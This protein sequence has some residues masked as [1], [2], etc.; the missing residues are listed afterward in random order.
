[1]NKLIEIALQLHLIYQINL[2][3]KLLYESYYFLPSLV[4]KGWS[5]KDEEDKIAEPLSTSPSFFSIIF[6]IFCSQKSYVVKARSLC[7]SKQPLIKDWIEGNILFMA[8]KVGKKAFYVNKISKNGALKLCWACDLTW[9]KTQETQRSYYKW[10]RKPIHTSLYL[11]F[12]ESI[13]WIS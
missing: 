12:V 2:Q 4:I 5:T 10:H 3:I 7:F 1:M 11:T 8:L 9:P 6:S 13:L